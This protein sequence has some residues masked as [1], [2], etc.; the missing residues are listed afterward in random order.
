MK[1]SKYLSIAILPIMCIFAAEPALNSDSISNFA[2]NYVR[3]SSINIGNKIKN[4]IMFIGDGMGPNHISAA[5]I[6]KGDDLCFSDD[7]NSKWTYHGYQNT[8][9]LTSN[10]FTLDTSKT[11]LYPEENSTL[12]DGA[13]NPYGGSGNYMSNTCYTDSAAGGT[14]LAT[15]RK[16]NNSNIGVGPLG[17]KY[18]NLVEIASSLNKMTGVITTDNLCGATPASFLTH[19]S[20]R[21]LDEEIIDQV[22][23]SNANLV[24]A[25]TPNKWSDN[26]ETS[27]KEKG[28]NV[29]HSLNTLNK[30][31]DQEIFLINDL[32]AA[33]PL[34]PS[35]TDL[36]AYALDKLDNENGF[37]LMV[38]SSEIDKAS[39][40]HQAGTMIRELLELDQTIEMVTSWVG[41]KED[42][43]IVVTADHETGALY[44][45][46]NIVNK[47]NI[48]DEINFLSYNHSRTRVTVDVFGNIDNFLS[49]Y[50]D[51][52]TI[53]GPID[54]GL[55]TENK[56]YWHNTDVFKLC[57]SYL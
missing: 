39:H 55:P 30:D 3:N 40:S 20:S 53:Q 44:Y 16:T 32:C 13:S 29:S 35:L 37:F 50:N 34:A 1:I 45:D 23:T 56:N 47:E 22:M 2:K 25:E 26:Y 28:W 4:V 41:D 38:E 48:F 14:A 54:K 8:D 49:E 17:D 19:V 6:Y 5:E 36:T 52:L 10:G 43:L 9:S 46:R 12:Y 31:S 7:S 42:T 33:S 57:A 27:Y 18:D 24:M 51:E 11:L 15:G 21:H